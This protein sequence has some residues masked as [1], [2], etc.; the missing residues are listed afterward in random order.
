VE[1]AKAK[2]A[3][4]RLAAISA[5]TSIQ[6]KEAEPL[7]IQALKDKDARLRRAVVQRFGHQL[8]RMK[9][10]VPVLIELL[11]C[12][13]DRIIG[14]VIDGLA[15]AGREN[16]AAATALIEHYRN[17][18]PSSYARASVLSAIGQCG[19]NAKDVIPLCIE[20]LKDEDDQLVQTAVRTLTQLDPANKML[21]SALVDVR[22][23]ERDLDRRI[24]R[25]DPRGREQ[26]PLG[27]PA[28]KEL[29]AVLANDK[30]ADRRAGAAI[31]LGTMV[32]DAKSAEDALKNA[33][34]DADP[35]VRIYAADAYWLV[36]N[37]TR[38]PMPVLLAA[39]KDK[40]IGIRRYAAQIVAGMGKE[41][42]PALPQLLEALKDQDDRVAG[43]LIR[44]LSQMGRDAA[45][46]IPVLVDIVRNGGD[47]SLRAFAAR[48]LEP[49]GREAKDAV[50]G[51]LD[52]LKTD[53]RSAAA[54]VLVKIATP[55]EALPA[56]IE[57]LTEP[58]R[59]RER[60]EH[61]IADAII[62]FGPAGVGSVAELLQHKRAEV[63]IRAMNVLVRFGKQAQ[64]IVPQLIDVMDDKD[65][66]VALSAA[67]AVWSID[68][69]PEALPHFV[70]GLK[71]KTANNRARAAR[72]LMNMGAE[73]KSAVPDLVAACKDIDSTVR[74]E[75]Y[76]ALFSVDNQTA[77]E[78]GDPDADEK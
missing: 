13:D 62:Q 64:N 40:D 45:P 78:L 51:L 10:A 12:K 61:V 38:T 30:E 74:R 48:A 21:V 57:V 34:K 72:N 32:R 36:T 56:F 71:A 7:L 25:P 17:L 31:V 68:R 5:L 60:G 24:G 2:D 26:K 43:S 47:S 14:Q 55:T 11:K 69:R 44:G 20:A 4:T 19:A 1:Q 54:W 3:D 77:R 75:A 49:F 9:E 53:N 23:R 63:R 65:E 52:M 8:G 46:A 58:S 37:E 18:N 41:G 67:E 15:Q 22:G 27:P 50:P 35:R 33:L 16:S 73:A 66:D 42:S 70:R 39:L 29:C 76:R 6:P 28:I 59:E